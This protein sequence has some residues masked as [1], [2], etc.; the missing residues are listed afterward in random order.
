[1]GEL[2][3]LDE[4]LE[5]IEEWWALCEDRRGWGYDANYRYAFNQLDNAM[6]QIHAAEKL[7][8]EIAEEAS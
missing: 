5:I 7:L 6:D 4:A 2:R 1:M 8:N 3:P